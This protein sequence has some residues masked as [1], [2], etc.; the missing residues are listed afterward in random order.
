LAVVTPAPE[1]L[2]ELATLHRVGIFPRKR[3]RLHGDLKAWFDLVRVQRVA[4]KL[5]LTRSEAAAVV[6]MGPAAR[7]LTPADERRLRVLPERLT[8][9]AAVDLHLFRRYGCSSSP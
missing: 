7:H 3:E 5:R 1:H 8:V 6:R 4:W 2:R 9:T